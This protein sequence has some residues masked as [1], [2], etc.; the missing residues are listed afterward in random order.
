MNSTRH[1]TAP[2]RGLFVLAVLLAL[3][4]PAAAA[5]ADVS[6]TLDKPGR[7]SLGVFSA[8]GD[9]QVRTLLMGER[10]PAGSHSVRWDGLDHDGRPVEP[11]DYRWKLVTGQ[12][13]EATFLNSVGANPPGG[14]WAKWIGNH[15]GVNSIAVGPAGICLGTPI[16][17]GPPNIHMF[18]PN[19]KASRWHAPAVGWSGIGNRVVRMTDT[20]VV[21]LSQDARVSVSDAKTGA[22]INGHTGLGGSQFDVLWEGDKRPDHDGGRDLSLAARGDRFVIGYRDHDAVRWFDIASGKIAY[23]TTIAKPRRVA[24]Q[25]DG[26]LLV[27]GEQGVVRVNANDTQTV[28]VE[29][30]SL[31]SPTALAWDESNRTILVANGAPDNRILRF[32]E[33]GRAHV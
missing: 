27:L 22:G 15:V 5:A 12:G 1:P 29:A 30:K 25:A 3:C 13:L 7:V 11:G 31:V 16:A 9:V 23:E 10:F 33:I 2:R 8:D 26:G 14:P 28:L 17:E 32:A 19:F 21:A 24:F 4:T 20:S 18:E 6:F